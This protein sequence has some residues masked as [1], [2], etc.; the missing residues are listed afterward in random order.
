MRFTPTR[1]GNT[2]RN[3][4]A[5]VGSDGSPPHAWGILFGPSIRLRSRFTP[6]RV[7]NTICSTK[8]CL[9]SRFTPTRVGNTKTM[10]FSGSSRFTPTRVGNTVD[11]AP[12][13]VTF[14]S[15]PHAWGIARASLST[16]RAI[17]VHPHT[18]GE[19]EADST[20]R[21][22]TTV[23]PHTRGEF[24]SL[25]LQLEIRRFTPTRVGNT[26]VIRYCRSTNY[27][28]SPPHAWGIL[29]RFHI[30]R[31]SRGSPP[32]AWGILQLDTHH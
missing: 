29:G 22:D 5:P 8:P 27:A 19:H 2:A 7:G 15:P 31:I 18:R 30:K 17:P 21:L 26:A 20:D 12:E 6:T 32:H 13:S 4:A 11:L 9:Q 1:V 10:A 24:I 14:G 3:H 16:S 23:H 28:G 25:T